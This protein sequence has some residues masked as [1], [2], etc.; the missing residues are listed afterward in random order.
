MAEIERSR[1]R[2][3]GDPQDVLF[4]VRPPGKGGTGAGNGQDR[5]RQAGPKSEAGLKGWYCSYALPLLLVGIQQLLQALPQEVESHYGHHDGKSG[6][7]GE[8]G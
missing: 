1:I 3:H 7:H 8:V 5:H 2:R 6:R 4:G